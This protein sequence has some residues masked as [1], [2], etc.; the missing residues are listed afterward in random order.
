VTAEVLER[1]RARTWA[2]VDLD[3][4]GSNVR[5]LRSR[6]RAGVAFMAV[7]KADAYGHGALPVARAAVDAGAAWLGVATPEEALELRAAGIDARLLIL[8]PT[9]AP[10]LERVCAA[11]CAVTVGSPDGLDALHR[12]HV[13]EKPRAHLE[14]DT[15]MTRTGVAP[16]QLPALLAAVDSA[17][18]AVEGISTH[19]ACADDPDP[20][21]TRAQL[22]V[23]EDAARRTRDRFPGA[24][25]HVEASA[26]LLAYPEAAFDLVRVGIALYGIAPAPHLAV[27]GVR[28][29]MALRSRIVRTLRVPAGTPVSYGAT[30][31]ARADTTIATVPIGYADGYPRHLGGAGTMVVG[32]RRYPVVGRVCMD[33]TMLDVGDAQAREG[34]E[35]L[36][37]G[38]GLT[39]AE[40][41]EAAGTTAYELLCQVNRRVPR[42]YLR[43]GQVA[44]VATA[45]ATKVVKAA[46]TPIEV[47]G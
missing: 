26:G 21:I 1:A 12:L 11:R 2:T 28:P 10:W 35:V 45:D 16:G 8:G 7:V 18:V 37:F 24:L 29:A 15:G 32:G 42:V 41:A 46:G 20:A 39:A 22:A 43:G 4:V 5:A 13:A 23:F 30:Y 3:A 47:W 38:E 19:L 36:V 14:V 44:A 31:R 40:V 33:Y 6:L 34:D 27:E 17:R 25:A 9:P